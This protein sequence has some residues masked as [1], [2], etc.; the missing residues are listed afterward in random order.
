[1][2]KY[3]ILSKYIDLFSNDTFGEWFFDRENDGSIA[4][5]I[6]MPY[7]MYTQA[8]DDFASDVHLCWEKSGLKD[9][10]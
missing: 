9:Y 5:P 6:Q 7:A 1:M 4:H 8:V 3:D 2:G 10:I